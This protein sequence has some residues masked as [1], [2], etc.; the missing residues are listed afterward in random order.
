MHE[1]IDSFYKFIDNVNSK[2]QAEG[3]LHH[4]WAMATSGVSDKIFL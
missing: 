3:F 2:R 4:Q 1:I